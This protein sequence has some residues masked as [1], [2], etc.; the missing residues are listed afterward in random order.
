MEE[1]GTVRSERIL[2]KSEGLRVPGTGAVVTLPREARMMAEA[3]NSPR[4]LKECGGRK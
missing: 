1:A 3:T 4:I 2:G